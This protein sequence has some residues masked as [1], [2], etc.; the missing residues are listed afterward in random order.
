MGRIFSFPAVANKNCE[1]L[2][3]GSMPGVESL[4]QQQYYAHPHN[5]FWFIMQEVFGIEREL[6]YSRR[7]A[8]VKKNKIA[9]WDVLQYCEREGSLDSSI[10]NEHPNALDYFVREHKKLRKICCNGQKSFN[11]FKRH[12]LRTTPELFE[13]VEL[14]SLPSTS[15]AMA[16]MTREEKLQHWSAALSD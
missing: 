15:P 3:L 1:I 9:L 8:A 6:A 13:D 10:R 4:Q 2:I 14:I 5:A 11:S 7:L 12:F 16:R